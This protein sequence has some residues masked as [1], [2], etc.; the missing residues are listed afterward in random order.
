MAELK[1]TILPY[2]YKTTWFI[3]L[4]VVLAL[5][6]T[7]QTYQW[8]IRNFKRQRELLHRTVEERTYQLEQQKQLLE[9]QTEELSRQNRMLTLQNEKITRQKAQL[10]RMARKVQELTLDK[11]AFFT[12]ITHEFRTPITLI[13][14][15]IERALKL[16][17]NPQVIEQLNFVERNSKYLLSLVNQL[18]DFR[19]IESDKLNIVATKGDFVSFIHSLLTP[20]EVFAGERNI[21]IKHYFHM[22]SSEIF[23]DEE[24]M[25]KVITNLLS[26][27]IKFTPDGGSISIY[28]ATLPAKVDKEEKL[29]L[30]VSDTGTGIQEQDTAQIFNRFYQS[31]KQAK[32][33]V[34][35][36]TGTGIGLYLCKRIVAMHN[37]DILVRNN[38]TTGCSF[39]ILLPLPKEEN[40]NDQLIVENN[41]P[42]AATT[43]KNELPKE[44]LALT[45]LVV[46]DNA[47]MRGYIRSILRDY[48]NVLEATNGAEALDVLNNQSV[49]FIISDLMM[50]VM[51]GIELSRR[52]KETFTI[53]HIP[54]LMLTAKTSPETRLE[55]YRTGVDEY[56]LKPFDETLLLTRIE[57]IL[58]NRRRYQRKFK[59]NMDVEALNIEEESGDKK[60][61]NQVME[62]IKEH[63]KNPYFEVSDFSE[64]VGVSK[65]LLNK[66]LQ[67][68]I[69][70]SAGQFI[71]NYRLNTAREL[72]LKNRETKQMNIAEIA[73]EVGFNDPKYFARCFSKQFN[74]TPSELMNNEE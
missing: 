11:I 65:S 41:I 26:N 66:K 46:E 42:P 25:H 51:D 60:F 67:S 18:M 48:Y 7:W 59:T 24:A 69:G 23:F 63:Y 37:G 35:G 29:Y 36:Q 12:N 34:Y 30:C 15:P 61:I 14:G 55:S 62:A 10:S 71:R 45:I 21:S 19:K 72:L 13:I 68:L 39:R 3:L 6:A 47:D 5:L 70:Q 57:N 52:V 4:L 74:M 44:R 56:L 49:D 33:P 28:I 54:F 32:Y 2:F 27:A 8:R 20:F 43:E 1:V 17:Y 53:S 58:D 73:Y 64:A 50:P 22:K 38:H 31:K 16:S 40:I 9:N